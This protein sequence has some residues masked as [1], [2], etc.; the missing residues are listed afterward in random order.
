M[1]EIK[2]TLDEYNDL[3]H[4]R[5]AAENEAAA[6]RAQLVDARL[7]DPQVKAITQVG[8]DA[9]VIA[10]FAV[11]NLPAE[12][13]RNWPWRTL[14]DICDRLPQMPDHG[15]DDVTLMAELRTFAAECQYHEERRAGRAAAPVLA[16]GGAE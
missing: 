14:L 8:R 4:K 11:A 6:L 5:N 16:N 13:T 1:A 12:V 2:L 7:T 3:V 9:L 10:R 15:S